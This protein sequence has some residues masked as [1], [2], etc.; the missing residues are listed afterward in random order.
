MRLGSISDTAV[1]DYVDARFSRVS[2]QLA[3]LV[4]K[5]TDGNP[6]FMVNLTDYLVAKEFMVQVNDRW[7]LKGHT[8]EVGVPESLRM[9]IERQVERLS[10]QDQRMLEAASVAGIEFS[11]VV[12]GDV[13]EKDCEEIQE[14]CEGL[15][16]REQFLRV[17]GREE[18]PDGGE[19]T[20]YAFTHALYKDVLYHRLPAGRRVRLHRRIGAVLEAGCAEIKQGD[21]R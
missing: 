7:E 14:R 13:L 9:M 21:S 6:L 11:D 18:L 16:Q 20:R 10:P 19:T 5:R 8:R 4:Y 17:K 1:A 12:I 2:G 3:P 15:V